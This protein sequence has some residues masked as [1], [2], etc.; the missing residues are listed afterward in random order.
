MFHESTICENRIVL[1]FLSFSSMPRR[2]LSPVPAVRRRP[3]LVTSELTIAIFCPYH[4]VLERL[5]KNSFK[6]QQILEAV[7]G[8]IPEMLGKHF[9]R[10]TAHGMSGKQKQNLH[11]RAR[12]R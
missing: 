6:W 8:Q 1:V 11:C 4:L 3:D 12:V 7:Y 2:C 5:Q 10:R 9:Q